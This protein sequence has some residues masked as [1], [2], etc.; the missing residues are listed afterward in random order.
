M[1]RGVRKIHGRWWC[2]EVN[3]EEK[4]VRVGLTH[5]VSSPLSKHSLIDQVFQALEKYFQGQRENFD[6]PLSLELQTPFQREVLETL[7]EIPYGQTV[8]YQD[9]AGRIGRPKAV[10]AVGS[11]V[12]RN[13]FLI[14]LPCHRVLPKSGGYGKY[15]GG[16]ALK[17]ALIKLEAGV[18]SRGS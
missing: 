11:A 1:Y 2:V 4:L 13:P 15:R 14:I 7:R 10:R 12:G 8:S 9:I 5:E 18:K 3:D 16:E 6:F 17:E